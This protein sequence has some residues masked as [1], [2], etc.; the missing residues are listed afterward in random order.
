MSLAYGVKRRRIVE[1]SNLC[2]YAAICFS[3]L[4]F[5]TSIC[6]LVNL[7]VQNL[8]WSSPIPAHGLEQ[9]TVFS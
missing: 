2:K 3:Q 1:K 5:S 8:T 7:P 6:L 9:L 4:V